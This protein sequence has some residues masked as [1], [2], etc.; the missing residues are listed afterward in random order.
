MPVMPKADVSD[1]PAL[2]WHY[3]TMQETL[4]YDALAKTGGNKQHAAD[5]LR[6]NRRQLQRICKRC[7]GAKR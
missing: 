1:W 3:L 5:M 6:M 2:R 4:V 7:E